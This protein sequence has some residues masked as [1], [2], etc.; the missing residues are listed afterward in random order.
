MIRSL[1]ALIAVASFC[2]V[3]SA[4]LVTIA[5]F[6]TGIGPEFT[7]NNG[8][9]FVTPGL[10]SSVGAVSRVTAPGSGNFQEIG[11][12][13]VSN[14]IGNLDPNNPFLEFTASFQDDG[15]FD[16]G[17]FA[18]IDVVGNGTFTFLDT[19]NND[20]QNA[21]GSEF[22]VQVDLTKDLPALQDPNTPSQVVFYLSTSNQGGIADVTGTYTI[23]NIQINTTATA[24][25]E[26]ASMLALGVIG[27]AAAVR[28]RRRNG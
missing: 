25:P 24:V 14:F 23:D 13:D 5:D 28:R 21:I 16:A 19:T 1:T 10:E 18:K 11:R 20:L 9:T 4:A 12:V 8:T 27:T 3:G 26:P 2:S 22:V 17:D 15:S 6:E 7:A